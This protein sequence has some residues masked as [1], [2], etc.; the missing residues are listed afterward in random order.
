MEPSPAVSSAVSSPA[1]P[2]K[3][4]KKKKKST[5]A[6]SEDP[7][8]EV[9]VNLKR[10]RESGEGASKKICPNTPPQQDPLEGTSTMVPQ[11]PHFPSSEKHQQPSPQQPKSPPHVPSLPSLSLSSFSSPE[12]FPHKKEKKTGLNLK[13]DPPPLP[14]TNQAGEEPSWSRRQQKNAL[15]KKQRLFVLSTWKP[16][17]TFRLKKH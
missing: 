2:A 1:L 13:R 10:R 15:L 4:G 16:S 3:T 7:K 6:E 17:M 12:L 14:Q 11:A 8:I 5:T 9:S